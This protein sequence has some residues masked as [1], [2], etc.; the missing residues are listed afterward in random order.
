MGEEDETSQQQTNP[1]P[2]NVPFDFVL[3]SLPSTDLALLLIISVF[4]RNLQCCSILWILLYLCYLQVEKIFSSRNR[5]NGKSTQL[6]MK[7]RNIS[8]NRTPP[9]ETAT[10]MDSNF[11]LAHWLATGWHGPFIVLLYQP[12]LVYHLLL[13]GRLE[14][15]VKDSSH[16]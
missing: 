5:S 8:K 7:Q 2:E 9:N 15:I 14:L 4:L 13:P 12:S 16:I 1:R 6:I 10:Y 3:A 11:F